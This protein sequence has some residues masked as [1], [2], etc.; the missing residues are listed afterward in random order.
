MRV[1][2]L[3]GF[4]YLRDKN[5]FELVGTVLK[6]GCY[7]QKRIR[8]ELETEY[9]IFAPTVCIYGGG[10]GGQGGGSPGE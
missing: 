10:G 8:Q 5:T 3:F 6:C 2:F 1:L 7:W 4:Q 9:P